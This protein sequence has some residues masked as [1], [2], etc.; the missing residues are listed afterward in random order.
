MLAVSIDDDDD[1]ENEPLPVGTRPPNK[2]PLERETALADDLGSKGAGDD[3]AGG[4][5]VALAP[6][7]A[8]VAPAPD[9]M[10][11][12]SAAAALIAIRRARMSAKSPVADT[13]ALEGDRHARAAA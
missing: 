5:V 11:C 3:T 4:T 9:D 8:P 10:A 7:P 1:D 13:V 2:P 6:A 12:I